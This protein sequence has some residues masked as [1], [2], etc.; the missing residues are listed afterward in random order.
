MSGPVAQW[1]CTRSTGCKPELSDY[2]STQSTLHIFIK[3]PTQHIFSPVARCPLA[4]GWQKVRASLSLLSLLHPPSADYDDLFSFDPSTMVWARLS[5]AAD[6]GRPSARSSHGF[7]SAGG[8][9]YVHGGRSLASG[10]CRVMFWV[11]G[12]SRRLVPTR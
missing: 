6:D 3:L 1:Q 2:R 8:K 11:H 7:A 5:T 10:A 12:S 4:D 9:L